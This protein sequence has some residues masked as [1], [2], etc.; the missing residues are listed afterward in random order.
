ME[1]CN[2]VLIFWLLFGVIRKDCFDA[3]TIF[4]EKKLEED[5]KCTKM[6]GDDD[7]SDQNCVM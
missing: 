1:T 2:L 3:M 4:E 7:D 5:K 6:N